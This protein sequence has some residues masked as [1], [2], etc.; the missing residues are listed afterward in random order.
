MFYPWQLMVLALAAYL[1]REQQVQVDYLRSEV[2]I[3]REKL[4]SKKRL[5]LNDDQR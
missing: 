1:N 2:A 5:L 4:G 3:L